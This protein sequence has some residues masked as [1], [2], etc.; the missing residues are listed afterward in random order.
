MPEQLVISCGNRKLS[1]LKFNVSPTRMEFTKSLNKFNSKSLTANSSR[2]TSRHKNK[3][4]QYKE[5]KRLQTKKL[6]NKIKSKNNR[7]IQI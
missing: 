7:K 2:K 3:E 5:V 1:L 6:I 4:L